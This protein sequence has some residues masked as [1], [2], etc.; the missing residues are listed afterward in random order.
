VSGVPAHLIEQTSASGASPAPARKRTPAPAP[1]VRITLAGDFAR[2]PPRRDRFEQEADAV[3]ERLA[4]AQPPGKEL[5]ASSG[6]GQPL[7]LG[8]RT[9]FEREL[10]YDLASVRLHTDA[11]GDATARRH[12][13]TAV[14]LGRD[15][16]FASGA[17]DPSTRQGLRLLAHEV[18]HTAQQSAIPR[19]PGAGPNLSRSP[20][21]VPQRTA[22]VDADDSWRELVASVSVVPEEK[23]RRTRG[24][25][26]GRRFRLLPEGARLINSLWKLAKGRAQALRFRIQVWFVDTLPKEVEGAG[27]AG[28]FHP[29]DAN[30]RG[31]DVYVRN[32]APERPGAIVLGGQTASGIPFSHVDAESHMADTLHH[33]LLHV[34]FVRAG[35]STTFPTGHGVDPAK[36]TDPLFRAREVTFINELD[37]LE[38]KV[39]REAKE[40]QEQEEGRRL[41]EQ[42]KREQGAARRPEPVETKPEAGPSFVGAQVLA[43]GGAV[44]LGGARG[45]AIVGA[46]VILGRIA[47]LHV[48][49]RGVY[50]SPDHLLAGGSFG[51]RVTQTGESRPGDRV[52]NPLFFDIDAGVLAELHPSDATRLT[53][54]VAVMG[55]ASVGQ[56][57]GTSGARFFWK[58]GGYV[59][60]SDRAQPG[61]GVT[62]GGGATAGVGFRFQ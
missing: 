1:A 58:V 2:V 23:G 45:T 7:P 43:E 12:G 61:G 32:V 40:R 36:Q 34:E 44:G 57:Y 27:A 37:A 29:D 24:D 17:Y 9:S 6:S 46:D 11:G 55:S 47:A 48:G 8:L 42:R 26:A 35:L 39:H 54:N 38:A 3:A 53:N 28:Y 19:L 41:E 33:E 5:P 30:A 56:E 62:A 52:E 51:L 10:P 31:Y 22:G 18:V 25:E 16:S 20:A 50:L 15:V 59:I 49:P 21:G 60:I 4:D 13:A 14:T